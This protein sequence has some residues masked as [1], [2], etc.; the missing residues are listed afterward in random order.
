MNKR[1]KS[2]K[3]ELKLIFR[4]GW[5]KTRIS[6]FFILADAVCAHSTLF[7][8]DILMIFHSG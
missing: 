2:G 1:C 4:S 8:E 7:E 6:F 5:E 3:N